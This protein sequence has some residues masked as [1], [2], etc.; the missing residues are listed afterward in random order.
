MSTAPAVE[1]KPGRCAEGHHSVELHSKAGA[2]ITMEVEVDAFGKGRCSSLTVYGGEGQ[3]VTAAFLRSISVASWIRY[4]IATCR[5]G[6]IESTWCDGATFVKSL[7]PPEPDVTHLHVV[8]DV[9]EEE[10]Q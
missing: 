1:P 3:G 6:T 10:N 4:H 9:I 8:P 2:H 5:P 7:L